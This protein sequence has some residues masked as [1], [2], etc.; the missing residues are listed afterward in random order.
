LQHTKLSFNGAVITKINANMENKKEDLANQNPI[1]QQ[2]MQD[3]LK[4][5]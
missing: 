3:T 4:R 2:K 1:L 5:D